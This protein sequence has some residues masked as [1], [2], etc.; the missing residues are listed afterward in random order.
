MLLH[1]APEK[2]LIMYFDMNVFNELEVK[3]VL[4]LFFYRWETNVKK[5]Y[6]GWQGQVSEMR[7]GPLTEFLHSIALSEGYQTYMKKLEIYTDEN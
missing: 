5:C 3:G 7:N 4:L 6:V 1:S 2:H